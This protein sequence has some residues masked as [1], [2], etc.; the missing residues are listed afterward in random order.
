MSVANALF[1]QAI[2]KLLA[3]NTWKGRWDLS[4][5]AASRRIIASSDV[6]G[7]ASISMSLDA[8]FEPLVTGPS[9]HGF[10]QPCVKAIALISGPISF[11]YWILIKVISVWL[12]LVVVWGDW[13]RRMRRLGS[14]NV[15]SPHR[16]HY[17]G[18]LR[19][20]WDGLKW[21]VL[22]WFKFNSLRCVAKSGFDSHRPLQ[23]FKSK[24]PLGPFLF[25]CHAWWD[26]WSVLQST[27]R[28]EK[29][30]R[31]WLAGSEKA[32]RIQTWSATPATD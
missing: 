31:W 20:I 2:G 12:V 11:N 28:K 29:A 32:G 16:E 30:T 19:W 27:S 13:A 25:S 1:L 10:M 18:V 3:V 17:V 6:L 7:S 26:C 4:W 5:I 15:V 14:A 21:I 22:N 9:M 24:G 8:V 23:F